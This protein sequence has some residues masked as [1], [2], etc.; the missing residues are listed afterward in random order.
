MLSCAHAPS[1]CCSLLLGLSR[2]EEARATAEQAPRRRR[3]TS[4]PGFADYAAT[5]GIATLEGGG[6]GGRGD[7]RRAA[8]R[9]ARQGQAGQA[10]RRPRRVARR[11]RRPTR[12]SRAARKSALKIALQYDARSST[13]APT[14]TDAAF[15][16]GTRPRLAR[17]RGARRRAAATRRTT[18]AFFAGKPGESEGSVRYGGGATSRARRLS[19]PPGAGGYT[20]RGRRPVERPSP[21]RASRASASTASRATSMAT[22]TSRPGPATRSTRATWRGSRASPSSSM[23]EQFLRA[24]GADQAR[25]RR[26][27]GGRPHRATACA[28]A[29]RCASTTSRSAGRSYLGGTGFF[30]R[31][32][33]RRAREARGARRH[34]PRQGATSSSAA[35]RAWATPSASTS[36]SCR[37][38]TRPRRAAGHLRARDRGP[39][40][41]QAHRQRGA[42]RARRHRGERRAGD[43]LGRALVQGA[44][45][46]RRRADPVPVGRRALADL[47]L[48]R[49]EVLEG[50]GGHPEGDTYPGGGGGGTRPPARAP[51]RATDAEGR[52]RAA[53]SRRDAR[54][55]P[56]GP[57]RRGRRSRRGRPQG[58]GRGRRAARAGGPHRARHRRLRPRFQGRH[59]LRV[60]DAAQFADAADIKDLS[61]RDLTGDGAADLVVRGVRHVSA[62]GGPV[63]V[64][65][66]FVYQVAGDA[67]TRIFGIET[68]REQ[69]EQ[70]RAGAGAVHPGPGQQVVRRPRPPRVA[71][72]AG[73]RRLTPGRRTRPGGGDIEP[74]LFRGAGS[75]ACDTRGT[76]RSSPSSATDRPSE[77]S[78]QPQSRQERRGAQR[79]RDTPGA[80]ARSVPRDESGSCAPLGPLLFWRLGVLA[81]PLLCR[82]LRLS[83]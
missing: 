80:E 7:R 36:R 10:R 24:Q 13:S 70:A 14:S 28:S 2:A 27:A 47:A 61:A 64:E 48:G 71:R 53:T 25:A 6:G 45:R 72:R 1:S 69:G 79:R 37:A 8:P 63:D 66:L 32:L 30:F 20:L 5:H 23:I 16:A 54:P 59:G 26:R 76:A 82:G 67:I 33:R 49:V 46:E 62:D 34:R 42:P 43:E 31:D 58:A 50:Q 44:D 78:R 15:A 73:P 41:R 18:S 77:E 3:R 11:S 65:V 56:E 35:S 12:S 29:S 52:A 57:R 74:L 9:G 75:A 4:D 68:A 81:A 17:A 38:M 51:R 19:R 21:R 55:V 40:V 22:A 60:P 39:A 83:V